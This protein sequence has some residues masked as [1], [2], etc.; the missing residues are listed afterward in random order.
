MLN[1]FLVHDWSPIIEQF[2]VNSSQCLTYEF[3]S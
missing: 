1:Q 3:V 2:S